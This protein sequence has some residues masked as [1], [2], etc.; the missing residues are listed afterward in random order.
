MDVLCLVP[1]L[2]WMGEAAGEDSRSSLSTQPTWPALGRNKGADLLGWIGVT[3]SQGLEKYLSR[4]QS[5]LLILPHVSQQH[6]SLVL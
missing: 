4:L 2:G 6:K 5:D 3:L 1:G